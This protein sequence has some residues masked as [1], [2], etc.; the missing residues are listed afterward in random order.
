MRTVLMSIKPTYS[1]RILSREKSFELRRTAVKLE[2]GDR[3]VVYA[4]SPVKA[5][6]GVFM[7]AG[8][9]RGSPS[10]L[11]DEFAAEFGIEEADYLDYFD[12]SD[13]VHAIRVGAVVQVKPVSLAKLR[14][15]ITGFRPPQSYQWWNGDLSD[16]VGDSVTRVDQALASK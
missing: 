5:V 4:S 10:H 1:E 7:V 8:V 15:R 12:G 11:W 14:E 3:V 6:V 9:E 16:L 13:T 2:A